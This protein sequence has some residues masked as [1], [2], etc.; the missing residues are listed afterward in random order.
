MLMIVVTLLVFG[1]C[2]GSF[3]NALVWRIHEQDKKASKSHKKEL[4]VL[5]GR[6][7]C[8][9]CHHELAARDLIP[10]LSWIS[11][12]GRC[13]YCKKP[14][15]IQY[16]LVEV[17]VGIFFVGSYFFWPA[18]LE[19]TQ[20]LSFSLWLLILTGLM[21][22]LVY[23][24]RWYLLPN[25]IM[26]PLSYLAAL[27]ALVRIIMA[28]SPLHEAVNTVLAVVVGGGIFYVIFQLSSGKWIG[29]GD[30]KLG[31][32]LGL[33]VGS[34]ARSFLM[35]F[36]ASILGTIISLP[37]LAVNKMKRNS[38]MPFGPLLIAAAIIVQFFGNDIIEWYRHLLYI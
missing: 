25:R 31:W 35:I 14:I 38:L 18:P 24:W 10:V 22:L 5:K 36:L 27:F 12:R 15:S 7:M 23:D 6:S 1:L 4:S 9:Y 28:A 2:L 33:I 11:L 37:L 21:A 13:R 17:I 30:V 8:P 32:M 26:Y 20:W 34:P 16:P 29:G 3:V 19:G